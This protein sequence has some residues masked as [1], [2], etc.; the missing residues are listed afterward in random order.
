MMRLS[1]ALTRRATGAAAAG[2]DLVT[3]PGGVTGDSIGSRDSADADGSERKA[4]PARGAVLA[5]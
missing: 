5:A 2:T 4:G 1:A 3:A